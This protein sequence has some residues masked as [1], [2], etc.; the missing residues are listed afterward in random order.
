MVV[1]SAGRFEMGAPPSDAEAEPEERP[2]REVAVGN[3]FALGRYEVTE[4]QW[5]ACAGDGFCRDEVP[6]STIPDVPKTHINWQDD[7]I[8]LWLA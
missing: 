4:R 7:G 5:A 3:S 6:A 2:R 8:S 1:I